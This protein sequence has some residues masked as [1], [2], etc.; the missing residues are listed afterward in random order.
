M[1]PVI[2]EKTGEEHV[3]IFNSNRTDIGGS[4]PKWVTTK[5]GK[6]MFR[7]FTIL[8]EKTSIKYHKQAKGVGMIKL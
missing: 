1:T 7:D 2:D 5:L 6:N 8:L 4:V 3:E